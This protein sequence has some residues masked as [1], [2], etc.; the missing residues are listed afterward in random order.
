MAQFEFE[1]GVNDCLKKLEAPLS[2]GPVPRW[3]R[4]ERER[5][6]CSSGKPLS[7]L[8]TSSRSRRPSSTSSKAQTYT[9]GKK[10]KTPCKSPKKTP[11]KSPKKFGL[12]PRG[13]RFIPSRPLTDCEWSHFQIMQGSEGT[14][15][16]AGDMELEATPEFQATMAENLGNNPSNSKILH[17]KS[18][19]PVTKEGLLITNKTLS[20]YKNDLGTENPSFREILKTQ[21]GNRQQSVL[22]T[23]PSIVTAHT[24]CAS[25]DTRVSYGWCLLIQE[26]FCAV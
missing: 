8:Q 18:G 6:L 20:R 24:F 3:Q 9:P 19:A 17:F 12:S 23:V 5:N 14:D 16:S 1:A 2:R 21:R 26:Y 11:L 22:R 10:A 25:R 15:T 7:P 13:D 4:K